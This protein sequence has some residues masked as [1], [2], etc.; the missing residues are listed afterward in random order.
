[1]LCLMT[2]RLTSFRVI[3]LSRFQTLV[4]IY[5]DANFESLENVEAICNKTLSL[6]KCSWIFDLFPFLYFSDTWCRKTL[7][8]IYLIYC[9]YWQMLLWTFLAPLIHEKYVKRRKSSF[10]LKHLS[11]Y[12]VSQFIR[13]RGETFRKRFNQS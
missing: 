5:S 13:I 3:N 11:S 6:V 9:S 10:R 8:V 7:L 12:E 2:A 4:K 1:M